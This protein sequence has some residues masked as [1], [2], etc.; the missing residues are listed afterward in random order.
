MRLA[1]LYALLDRST[2]IG[3]SH[4]LAGLALWQYVEESVRHIFGDSL[5]DPVADD[6]LRLL[7]SAPQGLT[8]T[9]IRDYFQRNV[10]Q[11]LIGRA[12]GLLLQAK[13]VRRAEAEQTGGRPAERWYATRSNR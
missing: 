3:A 12:L 13:L 2:A 7:R 11:E 10:P 5:G 1:M 8:R 4:L 9:E 6:L